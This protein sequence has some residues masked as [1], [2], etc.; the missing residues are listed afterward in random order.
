MIEGVGN[1][2]SKIKLRLSLS[3]F[4]IAVMVPAVVLVYYSYT[5]LKWEAFYQQ[6]EAATALSLRINRTLENWVLVEEQRGVA[7]YEF[8]NV[9][10]DRSAN[11]LQPSPLSAYPPVT[12]IP[13]AL[14]FFQ[15][16]ANGEF[17]TPTMPEDEMQALSYGVSAEQFIE[18]QTL[19]EELKKILSDNQLVRRD[20][21]LFVQDGVE[22]D[23]GFA[24]AAVSDSRISR[25]VT[26]NDSE[27][28]SA[29]RRSEVS[30]VQ[31]QTPARINSNEISSVPADPEQRSASVDRQSVTQSLPEE[32]PEEKPSEIFDNF[33][34]GSAE[35]RNGLLRQQYQRVDELKIENSLEESVEERLKKKPEVSVSDANKKRVPRKE[36]SILPASAPIQNQSLEQREDRAN[37]TMFESEIDP[38]EFRLLDS[39][40]LVF[41]RKV[42]RDDARFVQGLVIDRERFLQD[43]LAREFR[44][45]NLSLSTGLVVA[46]RG[47]VLSIF[48]SQNSYTPAGNDAG[49]YGELLLESP[50]IAP[51]SDVSLIFTVERL[52]LGIGVKVIALAAF[53][54][55]LVMG[56]G[57]WLMYR[58]GLRQM[59]LA[60]QQQDFVS[61]VS[62]ELKTPLTSVRMYGELLKQG[63]ASEDKKHQYYDY[64]VD[65]SERLSRLINNVLQLAKMNGKDLSLSLVKIPVLELLDNLESKLSAQVERAGF[66][67]SIECDEKMK[68]KV[69]SVDADAFMQI[70]INLIDNGIKFSEK[71]ESLKIDVRVS[72]G[73]NG[74]AKISVRDYGPGIDKPHLNK[75]FGLFY[76]AEN[77]LT[78][79]TVGTGIGLALV[80]QLIRAMSGRVE[81]VNCDPG[82]E[83]SLFLPF[84][85]NEV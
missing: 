7:D 80:E 74:Y 10:G 61:A 17:S 3:A 22:S 46:Y 12:Q 14:G 20:Q 47:D 56:A 52:Q 82:A 31:E 8:L 33:S 32:E 44:A 53:I 28:L 16:S 51:F 1:N 69:L 84:S 83:F 38:F 67:L 18:R 79:E 68:E 37:I 15:V 85:D 41:Y 49:V 5:Q 4:F 63:W 25:P 30:S 64:I 2:V 36:Q 57:T 23:S 58:L 76:R 21:P 43:A 55:I 39:G 50:L 66:T 70:M 35:K 27:S 78:R 60:Q 59:S 26:S 62:H 77:E 72:E 29:V 24:A 81:V 45:S 48:G 73:E 65:E 54:L 6:R 11:F 9:V 19:A 71:S 13:G 75:I 34:S 40:H 42:W